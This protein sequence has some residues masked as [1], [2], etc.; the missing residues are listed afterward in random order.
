MNQ[1][2][3]KTVRCAIYIRKSSEGLEQGSC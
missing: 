2:G 1:I 3:M